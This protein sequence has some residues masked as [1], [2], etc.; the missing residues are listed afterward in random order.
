MATTQTLTGTVC[1]AAPADHLSSQTTIRVSV[2]RTDPADAPA[3]VVAETVLQPNWSQLQPGDEVPFRLTS[4]PDLPDLTL[5]V[6][7]SEAPDDRLVAGN[8]I[9]M[10]RYPVSAGKTD[11]YRLK[12]RPI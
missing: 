12:V 8:F 11:G 4:V 3:A 1:F 7:V 6:T 2:R 9:T 5:S 10:E